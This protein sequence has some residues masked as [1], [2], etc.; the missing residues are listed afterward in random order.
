MRAEGFT[1]V[2]LLVSL[3]VIGLVLAA[4]FSV[5]YQSQQAYLLGVAGL[6][7]QQSAR[8]ALERMAREIQAAG[9]DP[10]G[11]RFPAIVNPTPTSLTIQ[12]DLNRNGVI[13]AS[14]ETVTY[15]LRDTTLR[16]NA[17]GGAQPVIEGVRELAF[18]YL[19]ADGVPTTVPDRI[20][21]VEIRLVVGPTA[22]WRVPVSRA[23]AVTMHTQVRLRNR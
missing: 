3:A 14:G 20:R 13:D 4:T 23:L 7:A 21:S 15:L 22:L 10:T 19:D 1:L 11:A 16:R 12:R 6:E 2:E 17:G 18:A 5:L 8:V 9:F